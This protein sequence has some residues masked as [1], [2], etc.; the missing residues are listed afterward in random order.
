MTRLGSQAL[1]SWGD[2]GA[3]STSQGE[4]PW[5]LEQ[6]HP[7]RLSWA[8]LFDV[9]GG[10]GR[11]AHQLPCPLLTHT[12]PSVLPGSARLP[13]LGAG[14]GGGTCS[15]RGGARA[16]GGGLALGGRQWGHRGVCLGHA[17]SCPPVGIPA[18]SSEARG[19]SLPGR[20]GWAA[21]WGPMVSPALCARPAALLAVGPVPGPGGHW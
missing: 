20:G 4:D 11:R 13:C 12:G 19:Q 7:S 15:S 6:P 5:Q 17:R 9:C 16:R 2:G 21:A 14:A 1:G 3:G 8:S 18:R 10:G